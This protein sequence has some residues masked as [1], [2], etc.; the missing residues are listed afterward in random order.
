[1]NAQD[2]VKRNVEAINSHN[3]DAVANL[4]TKDAVVMDPF[5]SNPLKGRAEIRRDMEIFY[6]AFPDLRIDVS[7]TLIQNDWI[8]GEFTMVGTHK[9]ALESPTGNIA[10]TDRKIKI[11]IA[12]FVRL[13]SEGLATENNRYYDV[14]GILQQLG[15]VSEQV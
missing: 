1:M 6:T 9:G 3:P 4:F 15:I 13:N 7:N 14:A 10:P 8:A 11:Q 5:Y 12:S 2:F